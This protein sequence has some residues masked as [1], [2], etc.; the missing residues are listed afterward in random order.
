LI[1]RHPADRSSAS[2]R[3]TLSKPV[4]AIALFEFMHFLSPKENYTVKCLQK[5]GLILVFCMAGAGIANPASADETVVVEEYTEETIEIEEVIVEEYTEETV[6][7]VEEYTE[8]VII[9]E[10]IEETI[11]TVEIVEEYSE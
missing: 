10:Y 11:E 6:E 7:V 1:L 9:E 4:W 8:E 2:Y 3:I 5:W